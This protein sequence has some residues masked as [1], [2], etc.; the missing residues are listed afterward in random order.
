MKR[1]LALLLTLCM[2]LAST[3]V[4]AEETASASGT[5]YLVMIGLTAGTFELNEDGSCAVTFSNNGEEQNLAGTWTQEEDKISI[6]IDNGTLSLV[7]DGENLLFNLED[8]AALGLEQTGV[9]IS[10]ADLSAFSSLI[11]ISREPGKVTAEELSAYQENGTLPEGKTKEDMDAFMAEMMSGLF[12][13][14]GGMD[15]YTEEPG[16]DVTVVEDN[17]YVREGYGCQ[18]GVYL[19]K[20]QNNNDVAVYLSNGSMILRDAENNEVGMVEYLGTTGSTY[21]EPGEATFISIT[22]D[23]NEGAVV[24]S[25]NVNLST[26]LQSYQTPDTGLDVSAVELREEKD[27]FTNYYAAATITNTMDQPLSDIS[28]VIAVRDA[29]GKLIDVTCQGLYMNE[30][31]AGSS[32]T[33]VN[34]LDSRAVDYCTNNGIALGQVEAFAWIPVK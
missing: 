10:S 6:D 16:P 5:W 8:I 15:T 28:A 11:Q 22:A 26:T 30:L 25:Y 18:E 19:A 24:D 17:F 9:D 34:N 4:L 32:I 3:S 14:M 12:S 33:L 2:L 7:L 29:E 1:I 20:I 27:Y 21:L 23:V 31:A 13:L